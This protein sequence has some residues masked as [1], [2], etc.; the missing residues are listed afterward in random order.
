M[1]RSYL[2]WVL[3]VERSSP[4]FRELQGEVRAY[5]GIVEEGRGLGGRWGRGVGVELGDRLTR[6]YLAIV[7]SC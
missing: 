5:L 6:E 1:P 7:R 2:E 3:S 4:A